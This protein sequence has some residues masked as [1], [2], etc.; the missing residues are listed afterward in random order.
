MH[1][2]Y[3]PLS[4]GEIS[5]LINNRFGDISG[6]SS[7]ITMVPPIMDE[8]TDLDTMKDHWKF[9]YYCVLWFF[10]GEEFDSAMQ[11]WK[12]DR[13][14][15][16]SV[17][18]VEAYWTYCK[19]ALAA[20]SGII[21]AH[22]LPIE[23]TRSFSL[24]STQMNII[25]DKLEYRKLYTDITNLPKD[26][27]QKNEDAFVNFHIDFIVTLERFFVENNKQ[28]GDYCKD[29]NDTQLIWM[30]AQ[31]LVLGHYHTTIPYFYLNK[32]LWLWN[33]IKDDC[34]KIIWEDI[35]FLVTRIIFLDDGTMSDSRVTPQFVSDLL[36]EVKY[37]ISELDLEEL[38]PDR[39]EYYLD[40]LRGITDT[41][42]VDLTYGA[43]DQW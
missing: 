22:V 29:K 16:H 14:S 12:I 35:A 30:M 26:I 1:T 17:K 2:R 31:L 6:L 11:N 7:M 37:C 13:T 42:Q 21:E 41:Y 24:S 28:M 19:E 18:I 23:K 32:L 36:Q 40:Y 3:Q 15:E 43:E 33:Y 4:N 25:L 20:L 27:Y 5:D 8:W 38:R 34:F 39:C 10:Y 9:P